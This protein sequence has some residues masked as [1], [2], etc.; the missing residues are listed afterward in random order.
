M[1]LFNA[2]PDK[3]L[4]AQE[5]LVTLQKLWKRSAIG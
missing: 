4:K 5:L 3:M 1:Y 2:L